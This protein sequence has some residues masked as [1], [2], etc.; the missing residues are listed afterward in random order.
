MAENDHQRPA[1]DLRQR[2]RSLVDLVERLRGPGGCP[3]D[4]VQTA[5]DLRTYILEETYEVIDAIDRGDADGLREEL[6]DLFFQVLFLASV[7]A[8]A[9]SFDL[10]DV[11]ETV[12]RKMVRRHPHVFGE[13]EAKTPGDV[14]DRWTRIKAREKKSGERGDHGGGD[15]FMDGLPAALPALYR[16]HK[17]TT[18]AAR[19]DFDWPDADGVLD[20]LDEE[21]G[22]FREALAAG[23]RARQRH[24]IGDLLFTVA[25]L[26]RHCGID[27][28]QALIDCN[29]R[30]RTRFHRM[31]ALLLKEGT[32][33]AE[34]RTGEMEA[35]WERAKSEEGV[36]G[37][38]SSFLPPRRDP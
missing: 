14:V 33:L 35:M 24:E 15:G 30:F 25:N 27:P 23:N 18:R 29:G 28:E 11:M 19:V 2:F 10:G 16:A 13:A 6:G 17:M 7:G 26:S 12:E 36:D 21:L 1:D 31:E 32:A 37:D 8:E 22:E 3:W 4:R 38:P 20:K 5:Q 34:A 9:G